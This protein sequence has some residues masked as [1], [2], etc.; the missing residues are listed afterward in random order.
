M[1]IV[2]IVAMLLLCSACQ[3]FKKSVPA[4]QNYY[5]YRWAQALALIQEQN[6]EEA[7]SILKEIYNGAQT[8]DPELSTR[9]LFEL[10]QINERKG[11]WLQALS[12]FKECELNKKNLPGFKA[13][14]EL[15]S[16][17]AGLYATL[18]EL[19]I[20]E[21]YA[22]KVESNLQIYMQQISMTQQKNWWAE[23][24]HRMGSFPVRYITAEN[25]Q[26]FASRF[27]STSQYLIR[28]MELADSLWSQR[29]LELA[30]TF[31]KKSF[32]LL[33]I[34]PNDLEEN[35]VLL[36]TVVRDRIN[37][38]QEI[39]QKIQLYKPLDFKSS[40][41]VWLFYQSIDDYQSQ[42]NS[43]LYNI[44]DSAPLSKE[45]QKRNAIEREGT[46]INPASGGID[47]IKSDPNL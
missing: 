41:T 35:S 40:R 23:T 20:S 28:S 1:K 15:P 19:R 37:T 7:E 13:E 12:Q 14:L 2:S 33:A 32:E 24:F 47:R 16:R 31:F 45:S 46:L 29:S 18:G 30:Q 3:L 43:V 10:G 36:G 6:F 39:I 8:A 38:L 44:R 25:W 11:L 27:H 42:I 34:S 21:I 26:D 4:G 17:L 9:A 5:Q 22:K